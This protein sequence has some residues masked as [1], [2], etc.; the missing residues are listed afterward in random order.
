MSGADA[1][2]ARFGKL[3]GRVTKNGRPVSH[4]TIEV[5]GGPEAITDQDGKYVFDHLAEGSYKVI[6]KSSE[7]AEHGK[8]AFIHRLHTTVL[9]FRV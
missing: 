8:T 2:W 3:K 9:D 4:L 1:Q 5:I 7:F 6:I